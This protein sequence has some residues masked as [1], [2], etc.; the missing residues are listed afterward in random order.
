MMA[1]APIPIKVLIKG[2]FFMDF[3]TYISDRLS[4]GGDGHGD[5]PRC[6]SSIAAQFRITLGDSD[7]GRMEINGHSGKIG[8]NIQ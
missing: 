5:S 3:F 8:Y 4:Y 6:R 2:I 1:N 7:R